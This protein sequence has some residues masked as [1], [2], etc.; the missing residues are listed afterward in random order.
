MDPDGLYRGTR[1][2]HGGW[3][4]EVSLD[5]IFTACN[6]QSLPD[7]IPRYCWVVDVGLPPS[8]LRID[9]LREGRD[10]SSLNQGTSREVEVD[11]GCLL[12]RVERA[13]ALHFAFMGDA[14]FPIILVPRLAHPDVLR[15]GRRAL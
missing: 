9:A 4:Q 5:Q 10:T 14:T 3:G 1:S 8:L 6:S 2:A 15:V 7:C 12:L 13:Q 11:E